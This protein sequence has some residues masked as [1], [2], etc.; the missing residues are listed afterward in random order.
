MQ[1]LTAVLTGEFPAE[2]V[3]DLPDDRRPGGWQVAVRSDPGTGRLH[4]IE[5]ALPGAPLLWYV[6]LAE[7][8]A[9]PAATTLVA[10]SDDRFADGEVLDADQARQAGVSGE[11]QVAAVRW[12]TGS[13]LVHQ[14]YVGPAFRRRGVAGKLVQAAAGAQAARGLPLVHGD[15]R[16]TDLGEQW[17]AGLPGY[18]AV[19]MAQLTHRMAAMTP[20]S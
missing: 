12:W 17:R 13:G 10:F 8:Q 14:V 3:V 7:P 16:R 2:S 11:Q 6:E 20:V 4:R 5:V 19:R 1:T 15:G 18:V 9:D